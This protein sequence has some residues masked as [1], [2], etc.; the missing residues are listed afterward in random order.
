MIFIDMFLFCLFVYLI[1]FTDKK[2]NIKCTNKIENLDL[3]NNY[4]DDINYIKNINNIKNINDIKLNNY[5]IE[6]DRPIYTNSHYK[7]DKKINI[8]NVEE[9]L[10]NNVYDK[11]VDDG[12]IQKINYEMLENN[13][14][15]NYYNINN[16]DNYGYTDFMTYKK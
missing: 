8:N 13:N 12:R 1:L 5:N 11:L 10:I 7:N 6:V 15:D 14:I 2:L 16:S 9:Q 4:I 3:L